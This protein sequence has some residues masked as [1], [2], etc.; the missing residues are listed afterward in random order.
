MGRYQTPLIFFAST[1]Y[2]AESGGSAAV[3]KEPEAEAAEISPTSETETDQ[4]K[5]PHDNYVNFD[6]AQTVL[7]A[8]ARK[9][10]QARGKDTDEGSNLVEERLLF[11]FFQLTVFLPY[12]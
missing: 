4:D 6:I 2:A 10:A 3:E 5:A 1:R 11:L 9:E 12:L 7:E 8:N